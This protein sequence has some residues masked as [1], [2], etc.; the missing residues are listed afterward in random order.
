M[1]DEKGRLIHDRKALPVLGKDR[2]RPLS[3]STRVEIV[4]VEIEQHD[5]SPLDLLE[6]RVEADRVETPRAVKFVETAKRRRRGRDD[7]VDIIRDVGCHQ[8]KKGAERLSRQNDAAIALVLEPGHV[9]DEAS[10]AV[11]QGVGPA[12][13]VEAQYIPPA[14][15]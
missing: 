4:T 6:Q 13:T 8:R 14:V 1:A 5:P 3:A 15:A 9:V 10:C 2:S 12:R 11:G 7:S